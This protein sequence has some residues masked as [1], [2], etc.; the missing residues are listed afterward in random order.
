MLRYDQQDKQK[1]HFYE[2]I[3]LNKIQLNRMFI[4]FLSVF[5]GIL[6]MRNKSAV[7]F[8]MSF[9]FPQLCLWFI[10]GRPYPPALD[11]DEARFW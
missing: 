10:E 4:R 7:I 5:E 1:D 6:A 3:W 11:I 8:R 2:E 9:Q